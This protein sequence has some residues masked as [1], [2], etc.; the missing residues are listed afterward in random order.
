[1]AHAFR[2][3]D[4]PDGFKAVVRER[5]NAH[6]AK[7]G[8]RDVHADGWMELQK[9]LGAENNWDTPAKLDARLREVLG[10][11]NIAVEHRNGE[12]LKYNPET[13]SV[14]SDSRIRPGDDVEVTRPGLSYRD[15]DGTMHPLVLP[16]VTRP[17]DEGGSPARPT[18]P[19][20]PLAPIGTTRQVGG[21]RARR[22]D[23]TPSEI[24]GQQESPDLNSVGNRVET[25]PDGV[26]IRDFQLR[27]NDP[28]N[29]DSGYVMRNGTYFRRNGVAYLVEH[30]DT[31]EGKEEAKRIQK[32]LE[33]HRKS[34]PASVR[35]QSDAYAW[36]S[37][38]YPEDAVFA[39]RM[40]LPPNH[41][42]YTEAVSDRFGGTYLF[43]RNQYGAR[44]VA[45]ALDHEFAHS[46]DHQ[47]WSTS[48]HSSSVRW[49][50]A[51]ELDSK[52][53]ASFRDVKITRGNRSG[54]LNSVR[55]TPAA[56]GDSVKFP[57]GVSDYGTSSADENMP[58]AFRLYR[59]GPIGTA[60][61]TAD[62][63]EEPIWFRDL[64][65][66]QAAIL[67]DIVPDFAKQ[68][69]AEIAKVRG[70]APARRIPAMGR[71]VEAHDSSPRSRAIM[72]VMMR[73]RTLQAMGDVVPFDQPRGPLV[74]PTPSSKPSIGKWLGKDVVEVEPLG[75]GNTGASTSLVTF[76]DGT[77]RI[78]KKIGPSP[79]ERH[80]TPKERVD[81]EVLGSIL[82]R[83]WGFRAPDAYQSGPDELSIEYFPD[84]DNGLSL[85]MRELFDLSQRPVGRRLGVADL[86]IHNFDRHPGN[87]LQD[88]EDIAPIDNELAFRRAT[89]RKSG[90]LLPV[91]HSA[92]DF[93]RATGFLGYDQERNQTDWKSSDTVSRAEIDEFIRRLKE[94]RHVF[95]AAQ[96]MDWY[97]ETLNRL[98]QM[99]AHARGPEGDLSMWE[100]A[101]N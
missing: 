14:A 68:Q 10:R 39:Q 86:A 33:A 73:P 50:E 8:P 1:V 53:R 22:P 93:N 100:D 89:D 85:S 11:R 98:E 49:R 97:K 96:R 29:P 70:L 56:E 74:G 7:D 92:G 23:A 71:I 35:D 4:N 75:G 90:R 27:G 65:P 101:W 52:T 41:K 15:T 62:G 28:E 25:G 60:R 44:G 54:G 9:A 19:P 79:D 31:K 59:L 83:A 47:Q 94:Q 30:P 76:A 64:F 20:P 17:R 13:M 99:R 6:V 82:M 26:P 81:R 80:G 95:K 43:N 91:A 78:R 66:E 77:Q 5:I 55:L 48:L 88:P 36:V 58:E 61:L 69:Q 42:F 46:L 18:P 51:A 57:H 2:G 24:T 21:H 3:G 38:E 12:R 37:G 67:D 45:G 16:T 34:L 84:M 40:G 72:D 32:L 63:P 87:F